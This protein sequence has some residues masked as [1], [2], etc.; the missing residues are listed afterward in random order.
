MYTRTFGTTIS[1]GPWYIICPCEDAWYPDDESTRKKILLEASPLS[2]RRRPRFA[3]WLQVASAV[4]AGPTHLGNGGVGFAWRCFFIYSSGRDP[5]NDADSYDRMYESLLPSPHLDTSRRPRIVLEIAAF[6]RYFL[7][8][9]SGEFRV[10]PSRLI[11]SSTISLSR[12][13]GRTKISFVGELSVTN[14]VS[15]HST[16]SS[17]SLRCRPFLPI[18]LPRKN[19]SLRRFVCRRWKQT[20]LDIAARIVKIEPEQSSFKV[21]GCLRR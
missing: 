17:D 1:G 2:P 3:V 9:R 10:Y 8:L 5:R 15:L 14:Y 20:T 7:G 12:L 6:S 16:G 13:Q 18:S 19:Y 11:L 21:I 4:F